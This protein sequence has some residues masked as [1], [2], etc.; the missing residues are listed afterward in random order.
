MTS[1]ADAFGQSLW[2]AHQNGSALHV[3]E[4]DDGYVDPDDAKSYFQPPHR[5]P[6]HVRRALRL[7]RGRVLDIGCGAARHAVFLQQR[8]HEVLGIDQSPMAIKTA[9]ARGLTWALV[10][11]IDHV[12]PKLGTFDTVVMLGNNFGLFGTPAKAR[13]LLRLFLRVT[14]PAARII[15]ESNDVLKTTNPAHL[16]YHR[17]NRRRGRL[18]GQIRFRVRYRHFCTPYIS[19]LMVNQREMRRIVAGTGWRIERILPSRGSGYV[20]VLAKA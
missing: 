13:R 1:S 6:D 18:P 12:D 11:S 7:A 15:A 16:A 19:Y 3:I 2:D 9:R 5:W 20:A 10:M 8:G 14:S 4:R 17:R